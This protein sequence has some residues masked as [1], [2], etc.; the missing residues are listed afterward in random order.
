MRGVID[1]VL[2]VLAFIC[3]VAAAAGAAFPR[4]HLGWIG[5]A[6]MVLAQLI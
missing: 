4:I 5:L 2:L 3:L 1:T 6:L